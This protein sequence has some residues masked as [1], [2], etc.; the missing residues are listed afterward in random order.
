VG[1]FEWAKQ[2]A[3]HIAQK[4]LKFRNANIE[5]LHGLNIHTPDFKSFVEKSRERGRHQ[6]RHFSQM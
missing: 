6:I 1:D 2:Q 4:I 3:K 5:L